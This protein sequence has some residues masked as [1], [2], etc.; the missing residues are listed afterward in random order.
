MRYMPKNAA[1]ARSYIYTNAKHLSEVELHVY[2]EFFF[3]WTCKKII[4]IKKVGFRSVQL[5]K[6]KEAFSEEQDSNPKH[7]VIDEPVILVMQW[8][9]IGDL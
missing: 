4:V 3:I 9:Y 6:N 1:V 7:A 8:C 5:I 2:T